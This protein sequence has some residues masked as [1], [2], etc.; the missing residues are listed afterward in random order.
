MNPWC[1]VIGDPIEHS[2]SPLI[3]KAAYRQLGIDFDYRK[4]TVGIDDLPEFFS[5]LSSCHGLSVTMP[6]KAQ[7]AKHLDRV[8][9][10]AKV[11]GAINTAVPAGKALWAGFNTDVY[12]I[13]AACREFGVE[14]AQDVLILGAGSTAASAIAAAVQLGAQSIVVA[15]RHPRDIM[16]RAHAM[17][18]SIRLYPLTQ[19]TDLG[20]N[21]DLVI[22]TLPAHVADSFSIPFKSGSALLDVSYSHWPSVLT[23]NA[24]AANAQIIP[25]LSMLVHQACM[26]VSLMTSQMP[27]PVWMYDALRNSGLS[28]ELPGKTV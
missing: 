28:W 10:L 12:G 4:I 8:D 24:A 21:A 15:A 27:K 3:H 5:S 23:Q 17:G 14:W 7:I 26:Q 25:G 13:V 6:L 2:L 22:S 18:V 20:S 16:S 19:V 9:G 11:T 1:A